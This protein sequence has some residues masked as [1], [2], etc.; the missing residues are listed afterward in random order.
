MSLMSPAERHF[1]DLVARITYGNP[2]LP[3]REAL[4]RDAVGPD[5]IDL[6]PHW[7][8]D[9]DLV[10]HDANIQ[11]LVRRTRELMERLAA[12]LAGGG[13]AS[14]DE[15]ELYES[16]VLFA[17]YHGVRDELGALVEQ[18]GT[19]VANY[20]AFEARMGP[21]LAP[22]GRPLPSG[23]TPPHALA[24]FFQTRRAFQHI[25]GHIVG[26]TAPAARLK[27]EVWQSI[28][29]HD[30]RRYARSLY[31]GMGDV[32]TLVTGPS[33]TG[34]ELVARAVGLS[35]YIPFDTSTRAFSHGFQELFVAL[36]LSALSPT[37]IESELF[38]HR[39]GA[40][41]GAVGDRVGWLESSDALGTVFLDEIGEVEPAIQV[42]LLRVLQSRTFQRLG[43]TTSRRFEGKILCATNRDMQR[44][45]T[46][47]RFREDFYYRICSDHIVTPG[48]AEQLAA[49]TE[50]TGELRRLVLYI[51]QRMTGDE[52]EGLAD[53]VVAFIEQGL[54]LDY[55]WPGNFRELE[56]CV[57]S[58]LVRGQYQP[59]RHRR[60]SAPLDAVLSDISAARLPA[61]EIERRYVTLVYAREGTYGG[62]ARVLGLDRRTVKDRVDEELLAALQEGGPTSPS[63]RPGSR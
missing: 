50:L 63:S 30:M 55:A 32:S 61:A 11:V 3:G 62:A 59:A 49:S 52:A 34:K 35:G 18:G 43:D 33:G 51:A 12:R 26:T 1:A 17:E 54:G 23:L 14:H 24:F 16:L 40:F 6:Q 2:F 39:R 15:L 29:T 22:G 5:W 37:L 60:P 20:D 31:R 53:E 7:S 58:V 41:T 38:G 4:E 8:Q 56:Q 47:G 28:F 10:S 48:L 46:E 27:A 44:E 13:Q 21:L 42:K 36:N 25:F 9:P 19:R 45:M 57:R